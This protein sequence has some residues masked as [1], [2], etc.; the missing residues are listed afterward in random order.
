T[1]AFQTTYGG[2]NSGEHP[3]AV[4]MGIIKLNPTGSTRVYATYIG[5]SGNDQPHSLIVDPNGNL[6]LAG[7]SNSPLT[8]GGAYP[9]TGGAA[10]VI[11]PGGAQDIVVTKL[12]ATGSA[13]VGSKRIGG[14]ANDG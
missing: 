12:N 5:G 1:G 3:G 14:G 7:R 6:V 13:L 9:V 4:D 2:G 11:G 8:G 10:G